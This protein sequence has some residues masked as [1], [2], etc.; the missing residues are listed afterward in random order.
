MWPDF[1]KGLNLHNRRQ[2]GLAMAMRSKSVHS[3]SD[4]I[5]TRHWRQL[6]VKNGGPAVWDAMLGLVEQVRPSL[7]AVKVHLP[8]DFRDRSSDAIS[9]GTMAEAERFLA[10]V[11]GL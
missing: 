3:R 4:S 10:G 11:E 1:D 6:A 9:T 5:H 2:A 7:A 8:G